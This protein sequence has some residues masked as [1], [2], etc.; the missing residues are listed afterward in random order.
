MHVPSKSSWHVRLLPTHLRTTSIFLPAEHSR[1]LAHAQR[2]LARERLPRRWRKRGVLLFFF[3]ACRQHGLHRSARR[4][5]S[6][7]IEKTLQYA[8]EVLRLACMELPGVVP[9]DICNNTYAHRCDMLS[10]LI[11][12][13]FIS[14]QQQ[15]Q[16]QQQQRCRNGQN[17]KFSYKCSGHSHLAV[18]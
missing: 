17:M 2:G 14:S 7:W 1:D 3:L 8:I 13:A 12:A 4:F 16:Q 11:L 15:Q 5:A 6:K 18:S 9:E 10:R